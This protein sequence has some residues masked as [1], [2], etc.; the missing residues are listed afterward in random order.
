MKNRRTPAH[1]PLT[2]ETLESRLPLAGDI[3][4]QVSGGT[5]KVTGTDA[6]NDISIVQTGPGAFDITGNDG[7]QFIVNK[8][9]PVA[10]PVS[11]NG[12][13]KDIK[14]DLKK[15]DD[16]VTVQGTG[17]G[18]VLARNVDVKTRQGQDFVSITDGQ[19]TGKVSVDSGGGDLPTDD[20]TVNI[21]AV[22]IAKTLLVKTGKGLDFVQVQSG[23]VTG[24]AT[25]N[26]GSEADVVT[27]DAQQFG[28]NLIIN[29]GKATGGSDQVNIFGGVAI[30]GKLLIT[31]GDG[32]D[33]ISIDDV[34][35][36]SAVIKT[37]TGA[38]TID[39]DNATVGKASMN[40]GTGDDVLNIASFS[41][42]TVDQALI[43]LGSGDDT[44]NIFL[45]T[46][47]L[48]GPKKSKV[49]GSAG[50]DTIAGLGNL[51]TLIEPTVSSVE[52]II[53]VFQISR[54]SRPSSRPA[55]GDSR[56]FFFLRGTPSV[57]FRVRRI[58][59]DR[60]FA[61]S[62]APGEG[63]PSRVVTASKRRVACN[64]PRALPAS[65]LR[66][67]EAKPRH[68]GVVVY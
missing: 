27:S 34:T 31:T 20:D 46:L 22:S 61:E 57:A 15:G 42:V 39:F 36:A 66:S 49:T 40:T 28:K 64:F 51:V 58:R 44:V 45:G 3:V 62:G 56:P 33:N 6:D 1:R 47:T 10:G 18:D 35:A 23:N 59:D 63:V 41:A 25:L 30:A 9:A 5:L 7:E 68:P 65:V 52:N 53:S 37:G 67:R 21:F 48:N 32:D 50:D 2:F 29:T 19:V 8:A 12:V 16:D 55:R 38:D 11:V 60:C 17:I 26:S 14:I 24:N 4:V 43:S 54:E 13:T